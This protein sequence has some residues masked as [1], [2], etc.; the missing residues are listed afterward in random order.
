MLD[1]ST[2]GRGV[3]PHPTDGARIKIGHTSS[4]EAECAG[5][6]TTGHAGAI[7][8]DSARCR[9]DGG[10]VFPDATASA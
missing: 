9:P 8:A 10:R 7:A 2:L 6:A 1:D 4:A 5:R 3:R